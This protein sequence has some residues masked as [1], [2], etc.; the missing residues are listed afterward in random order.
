MT[1]LKQG[2]LIKDSVGATFKVM[3]VLGQI[4][5]ISFSSDFNACWVYQ[6]E[7][8]LK[9]NGYTWDTP[10]WEPSIGEKYWCIGSYGEIMHLSWDDDINDHNR[11]DFL[12]IYQTEEL[13]KAALLEI[14][15][16]LGK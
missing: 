12:G 15:R 7:E 8:Q 2:D 16:K 3:E 10:A 13:G 5:F 6:T 14:R 11:R 9:E 1:T 4:V